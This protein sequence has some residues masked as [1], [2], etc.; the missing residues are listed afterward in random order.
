MNETRFEALLTEVATQIDY[1]DT[2]DLAVAV[3]HRLTRAPLAPERRR[4]RMSL[5]PVLASAALAIL[6]ALG[7]LAFSPTARRAAADLLGVLGIRISVGERPDVR[8]PPQR[9]ELDLGE[10]LSLPSA[11]GE[12]DFP[13]KVPRGLE[14]DGIE[15]ATYLDRSVGDGGMVSLVYPSDARTY[16]GVDVLITQFEASVD[17]G[18]FKKVSAD[19]GEVRFVPVAGTTGYWV[20]GEPHLFY[21]VDADGAYREETVRLAGNVLLWES[22]RLTYR[23]EGAASLS[24]AQEI[25]ASLD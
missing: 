14:A 10:R 4:R 11:R 22:G 5:R 8:V 21:Y 6:I 18:F 13:V 3:T 24:A 16:S 12:V 20:T 25:A 23:I 2:P 17:E 9:S 1:P 15:G 7:S 19:G